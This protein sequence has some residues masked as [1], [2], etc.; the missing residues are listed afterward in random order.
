VRLR[1]RIKVAGNLGA[2][3]HG[4]PDTEALAWRKSSWSISN[5]NCV[6]VA[7]LATGHRAVRDSMD[8]TGEILS[9]TNSE[10]VVFAN[11]IK[12]GKS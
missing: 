12:G 10:W 1:V 4:L 11:K 3:R 8:K 2:V 7:L 5:G 9:F 6:E